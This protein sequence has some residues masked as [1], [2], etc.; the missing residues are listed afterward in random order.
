VGKIVLVTAQGRFRLIFYP[1]AFLPTSAGADTLLRW[2]ALIR[3][4]YFGFL[5]ELVLLSQEA[6]NVTQRHGFRHREFPQRP[7]AMR[8]GG[9]RV[10]E[11]VLWGG[12][13]L[14][15]SVLGVG[16][17]LNELGLVIQYSAIRLG[18]RH[19]GTE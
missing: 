4:Y 1:N 15:R 3:K 14:R 16:V 19:V 11:N 12:Q 10:S 9:R 2:L 5:C 17:E 7:D 6:R 18:E 13:R 8:G